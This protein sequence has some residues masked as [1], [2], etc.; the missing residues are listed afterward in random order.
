MPSKAAKAG[1][2]TLSMVQPSL[3]TLA[4]DSAWFRCFGWVLGVEFMFSASYARDQLCGVW[5]VTRD[6]EAL[7][8]L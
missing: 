8:W 6:D 5:E 1:L 2:G 7:I 4:C 3:E